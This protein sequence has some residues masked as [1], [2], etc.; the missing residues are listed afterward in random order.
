VFKKYVYNNG[1][2]KSFEL[3]LCEFSSQTEEYHGT[4][5]VKILFLYLGYEESYRIV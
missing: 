2:K 4:S 5:M 3:E 1:C